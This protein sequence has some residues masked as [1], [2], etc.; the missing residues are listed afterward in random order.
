MTLSMQ[1][2][3]KGTS[4]SREMFHLF[5]IYFHSLCF[6]LFLV[7]IGVVNALF[8]VWEYFYVGAKCCD[9]GRP[10]GSCRGLGF[11][12]ICQLVWRSYEILPNWLIFLATSVASWQ[13]WHFFTSSN[14]ICLQRRNQ[15]Q[16]TCVTS[17]PLTLHVRFCILRNHE[18]GKL[19][20][21]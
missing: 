8:L 5:K 7:V 16:V 4:T 6:F 21:K 1:S 2:E 15:F 18:R 17:K 12:K 9:D 13:F 20:E 14:K 11:W 19:E 10:S 3:G